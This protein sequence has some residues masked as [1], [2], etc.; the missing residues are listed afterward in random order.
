MKNTETESL[1]IRQL[2]N[3][4]RKI[5]SIRLAVSE[6]SSTSKISEAMDVLEKSNKGLKRIEEDID[7]LTGE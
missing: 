2:K 7:L 4:Q 1:S 5:H 3:L 6:C